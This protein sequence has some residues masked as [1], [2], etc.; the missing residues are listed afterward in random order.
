MGRN[1]ENAVRTAVD[2]ESVRLGAKA[3]GLG[4]AGHPVA[5]QSPRCRRKV[6][7]WVWCHCIQ[8]VSFQMLLKLLTH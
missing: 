4:S 6:H 3:L 5:P 2:I 1:A 7:G 8:Q